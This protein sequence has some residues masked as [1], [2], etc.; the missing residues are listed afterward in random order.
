MTGPLQGVVLSGTGGVWRVRTGAGDTVEASLRGRLKKA[1]MDRRADGGRKRDTVAA[2]A[3]TLKLAVGD[4]VTLERDERGDAW[5]IADILPRRS[6]LARRAPGGGHGERIVAA[7]VDQVV[8]V[9]AAAK[10]EP[11][12]R[13]LDRFLVIAESNDLPAR[14]VINKVDLTGVAAAQERFADY[15]RAGYPL[16][17]TSVRAD[18]GLAGLR[19]AIEGRVSVFTG[20]SGVGKSSLLNAL[21]PGLDLRVGEVSESVNKGRHTTVGGYAHPLPSGGFVLDTPG[22][23]EVGLWAVPGDH[24]DDYFP[25]LRAIR[26]GC[27]FADCAHDVEPDCA[28]REA[29]ARGEL[30]AARFHSY[31][32][33][34]DELDA[35]PPV[36]E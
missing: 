13:M 33:L 3:Q 30:S 4:E 32:L 23:R 28:V 24:L 27:R 26:D 16:H 7:N 18:E 11:H 5:A 8:I 20:P 17:L 14:V 15:V 34:R 9:F 1:D 22:L 6:Q 36:W 2:A 12:P 29:L 19:D 10:P 31:R 21:F 25:E 35:A